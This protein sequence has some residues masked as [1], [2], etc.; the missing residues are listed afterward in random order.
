MYYYN[1]LTSEENI[2]VLVVTYEEEC[3]WIYLFLFDMLEVEG[4]ESKTVKID[5]KSIHMTIIFLVFLLILNVLLFYI[6][7]S[8]CLICNHM[9][10]E[11]FRVI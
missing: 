5:H 10:N 11:D 2:L 1:V 4:R 9:W 7:L 3:C 6:F 8:L